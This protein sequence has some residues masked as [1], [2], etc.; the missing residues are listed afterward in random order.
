LPIALKYVLVSDD[1]K[2]LDAI[3]VTWFRFSL[4]AVLLAAYILLRKGSLLNGHILQGRKPWL[5]LISAVC[6]C[7][8]Y[9]FFVWGLKY[10][11]PSAAAVV[12]QLAPMFLLIGSLMVFKETFSRGQWAGFVL[13]ALGM[14][15]F[16]NDKRGELLPGFFSEATD[17][18]VLEAGDWLVG[19]L[20]VIGASLFWAIFA[21]GQKQLLKKI[22]SETIMLYIYVV[23]MVLFLPL[24]EPT[25][26]RILTGPQLGILFYCG[27]NTLF[28]Y[29]SFA[30]AL[31]H[32][33]A[34]RVSATV[35]ITPLMTIFIMKLGHHWFPQHLDD[36]S[37]NLISVLGGMMVVSGSM[38]CA[39]GR[40]NRK[41]VS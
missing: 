27:L 3:T 33:E 28:A 26:I 41:K 30:E 40:F 9:L 2:G 24:A 22:S 10:L 37:L 38:L 36:E 18:T 16:F 32:W 1:T 31:D 23:G 19:V 11:S 21:L 4:S 12:I 13:L 17:E 6:L 20:L 35:S 8:N 39:L 14:I 5:F 15:L 29:G 25:S 7:F 34:S